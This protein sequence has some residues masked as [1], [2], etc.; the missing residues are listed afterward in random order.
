MIRH[1]IGRELGLRGREVESLLSV[2]AQRMNGS[3]PVIRHR[4]QAGRS[5]RVPRA[6]APPIDHDLTVIIPAFNEADRLPATL[7]KLTTYLLGW[8]ID[9]RVLVADDGSGDATSQCT[10]GRPHCSTI[11]LPQNRGKGC[12][13]RTAMFHATG[14]VVAFTDADL[15]FDLS[16]LRS[17]YQT[18]T[19]GQCEVVFGTRHLAEAHHAPRRL[20][21]RIASRVFRGV[22][23]RLVPLPVP[24]T[25]CGLKL[26]SRHAALDIF[27]RATIDGFA[28]DTEIV[29]LVRH[30]GLAFRQVAVVLVHEY[31]SSLSVTRSALPMLWDVLKLAFRLRFN[32]SW[33]V[34]Q[35]VYQP[36]DETPLPQTRTRAA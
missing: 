35:V 24:D 12:A 1:E 33:G 15:P 17:G 26:F 28:F 20:S 19:R 8:G 13:V 22:V 18:I 2:K 23:Q 32:S 9:Y 14:R 34:P 21:R 6:V 30:L 5:N 10:V 3:E 11:R 4:S 16:A 7:D 36:S 27:S 25:Q 29:A 31:S